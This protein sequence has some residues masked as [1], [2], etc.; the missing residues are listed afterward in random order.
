MF[1]Y[2]LIVE[3]QRKVLLMKALLGF[4]ILFGTP[5]NTG[6]LGEKVMGY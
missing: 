4:D 5:G 6:H 2:F 1:Q 3:F